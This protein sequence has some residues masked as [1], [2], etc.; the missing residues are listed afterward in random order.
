[1]AA[2]KGISANVL[3]LAWMLQSWRFT[4]RPQ[5]IPLFSASSEAHLMENLSACDVFMTTEEA[6]ALNDA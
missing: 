6:A 3:N 2:D 1:M 4:D 5:I